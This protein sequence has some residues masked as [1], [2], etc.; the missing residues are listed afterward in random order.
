MN[1]E[2]AKGHSAEIASLD[3]QHAH[4]GAHEYDGANDDNHAV[5]G[6]PAW[7]KVLGI[8]IA[9][10]FVVAFVVLHLAGVFGP[11]AH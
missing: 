7:L 8:M 6:T 5:T 4:A 2:R 3:D 10:G 1:E 11:G 9:I